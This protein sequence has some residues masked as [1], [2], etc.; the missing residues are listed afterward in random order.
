M[1]PN[2]EQFLLCIGENKE[3]RN[4]DTAKLYNELYIRI[5]IS[6]AAF[7]RGYNEAVRYLIQKYS[8]RYVAADGDNIFISSVK[9]KSSV[10]DVYHAAVAAFIE[11]YVEKS[12]EKRAEFISL[13]DDA[14][15]TVWREKIRGRAI[16]GCRF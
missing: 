16:R 10:Y 15:C 1:F 9:D 5:K 8:S 7:C 6:E 11:Y 3:R 12:N 4:M 14:Y 2:T 13:A